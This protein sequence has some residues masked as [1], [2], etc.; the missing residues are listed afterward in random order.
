MVSHTHGA[1]VWLLEARLRTSRKAI[2][3]RAGEQHG[4]RT[5]LGL[6]LLLPAF[7]FGYH[8]CSSARGL[9]RH[10]RHFKVFVFE[11]GGRG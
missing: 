6:V 2:N 8:L 10:Y 1:A 9:L 3:Q 11:T 7:I 5:I 4:L